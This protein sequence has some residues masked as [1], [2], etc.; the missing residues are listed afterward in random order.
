MHLRV[1]NVLCRAQFR[2]YAWADVEKILQVD[3]KRCS[4]FAVTWKLQVFTQYFTLSTKI[5]FVRLYPRLANICGT[6]A[7]E[8]GGLLKN[9]LIMVDGTYRYFCRPS[10]RTGKRKFGCTNIQNLHY[11]GHYY[12]GHGCKVQ[13]AVCLDGISV[14][15][16][17]L[18]GDGDNQM[19]NA[20]GIPDQLRA[21]TIPG[22]HNEH[23][24]RYGDPAYAETDVIKRKGKGLRTLVQ[25]EEDDSMQQPRGSVEDQIGYFGLVFPYFVNRLKHKILRECRVT[26]AQECVVANILLN[27]HTCLRGNQVNSYFTTVDCPVVEDYFANANDGTL[28]TYHSV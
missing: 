10:N 21:V 14:V 24:L 15:F 27:I 2:D 1:R 18:S 23:P 7:E 22:T 13:F 16:I 28:D 4:D 3:Q 25:E 26:Y 20:S 8:K 11:N 9:V 6:I 19:L 5:D 12:N 17:G